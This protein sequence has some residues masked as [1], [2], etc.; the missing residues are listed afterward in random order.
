ME[1]HPV[2]LAD[3]LPLWQVALAAANKSQKTIDIYVTGV[4]QYIAWCEDN[5]RPTSLDRRSVEEWTAHLLKAH[6]ASTVRARQTAVRRFSAWL[7]EEK[8]IPSNDLLGMTPP[9]LDTKVMQPLTDD[10]LRRLFKACE[11]TSFRDRRDEAL[12]RFMA[13]T[14]ARAAEVC[15]MRVDDIDIKNGVAT[16][17][18]GKGGRGRVVPFGPQTALAIGRYLRLRSKHRLAD[19]KALWLGGGGQSFS[20]AGM[21]RTFWYRAKL[22]S[23]DRLHPHLLRNTAATRWL[24][25]GGSEGGAMQIIGWKSRDMLDHYVRFTAAGRAIDE[26][27]ALGLDSV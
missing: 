9:K 13:E 26:S 7:Y 6:T 25:A 1:V 2:D 3:Q 11:G 8:E 5:Q 19:S 21:Q 24:A 23:I 17:V 18:R 22:S 12:M 15:G 16:I 14:G 20:Y 10:E 4:T 27:R